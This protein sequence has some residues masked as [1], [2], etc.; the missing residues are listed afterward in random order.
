MNKNNEA[1]SIPPSSSDQLRSLAGD[2]TEVHTLLS[3]LCDELGGGGV[4]PAAQ[5]KPMISGAVPKLQ[6]AVASM[7]AMAA[8]LAGLTDENAAS[9]TRNPLLM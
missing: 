6:E 3:V 8:G 2:L 1:S 9:A 5:L 4:V 7:N